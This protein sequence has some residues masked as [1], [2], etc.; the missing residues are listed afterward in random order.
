MSERLRV[1][2]EESKEAHD[3]EKTAGVVHVGCVRKDSIDESSKTS[4]EDMR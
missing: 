1:T 3:T 4:E 2:H